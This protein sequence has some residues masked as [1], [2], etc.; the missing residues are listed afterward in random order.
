MFF[1]LFQNFNTNCP[2]PYVIRRCTNIAEKFNCVSKMTNV[3][4]ETDDRRICDDIRRMQRLKLSI[5][6]CLV[7][8]V[9]D[10]HCLDALNAFVSESRFLPPNAMQA[11][12]VPSC[13]VCPSV[14]PSVTFVYSVETNRYIVKIFFTVEI[15]T[16]F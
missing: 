14:C 15:A 13:G 12:P 11:R 1:L 10:C 5:A 7:H 3:I 8:C 2:S 6:Y 9:L 4:D 16:S